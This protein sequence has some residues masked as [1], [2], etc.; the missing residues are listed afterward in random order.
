M[1]HNRYYGEENAVEKQDLWRESIISEHMNSGLRV[2]NYPNSLCLHLVIETLIT[3]ISKEK[4]NDYPTTKAVSI[5]EQ[6]ELSDF[7]DQRD[8]QEDFVTEWT[9]RAVCEEFGL[10]ENQYAEV[11]DERSLRVLSLDFLRL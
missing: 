10:S 2:A 4:S 6:L 9:R 8:F 3:E 1:W 7:V 5:G 11:F